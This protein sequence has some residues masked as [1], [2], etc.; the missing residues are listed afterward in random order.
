MP[1]VLPTLA[2]IGLPLGAIHQRMRFARRCRTGCAEASPEA[3]WGTSGGSLDGCLIGSG[4]A[5]LI[6]RCKRVVRG[7]VM[8]ARTGEAPEFPQ[9]LVLELAL[10]T[11]I[12]TL[13]GITP[14]HPASGG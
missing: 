3:G 6:R 10:P 11:N 5:E 13:N 2:W 12:R 8:G 7:L 4:R 1:V 14:A 9:W